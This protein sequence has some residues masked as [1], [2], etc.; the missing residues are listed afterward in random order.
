M[1]AMAPASLYNVLYFI[2]VWP[3]LRIILYIAVL[4]F[5]YFGGHYFACCVIA[6]DGNIWNAEGILGKT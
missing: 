3:T 6:E 4:S 2:L 1:F 5:V